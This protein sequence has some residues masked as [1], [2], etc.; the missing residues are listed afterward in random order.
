MA[1]LFCLDEKNRHLV[2]VDEHVV[3]VTGFDVLFAFR[4]GSWPVQD[5]VK[6]AVDNLVPSVSFVEFW[7]VLDGLQDIRCD[8]VRR[9]AHGD[10]PQQQLLVIGLRPYATQL[11][12]HIRFP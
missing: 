10:L 2:P 11:W 8:V 12:R 5:L 7:R 1:G 6:R 4:V 9:Y 3:S